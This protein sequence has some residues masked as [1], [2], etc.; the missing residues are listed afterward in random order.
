MCKP[1]LRTIF[2]EG[3][4]W[5][6]Q[7]TSGQ[8]CPGRD[9]PTGERRALIA[10]RCGDDEELRNLVERLL[11]RCEEEEETGLLPGSSPRLIN[12]R[13]GLIMTQLFSRQTRRI[14][15]TNDAF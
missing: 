12:L 6:I 1:I 5:V 3:T 4:R 13:I 15:L 10:T 2:N 8:R 14:L 11:V 7:D 9:A